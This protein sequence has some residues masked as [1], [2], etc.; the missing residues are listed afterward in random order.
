MSEEINNTESFDEA[1]NDAE[2]VIIP[3]KSSEPDTSAT[4]EQQGNQDLTAVLA[5][6]RRLQAEV[7]SLRSQKDGDDNISDA[8]ERKPA[9]YVTLAVID[10]MPIIDMKLEKELA[11][12]HKGDMY[13]KNYKAICQVFGNDDPV[14]ITYGVEG[15]PDDFLNLPRK[16]FKLTNQDPNDLSGASKVQRGVVISKDGTVPEIDRS[17]GVPVRTGKMVELVTKRDKRWYTIIV[18]EETGETCELSEDKLYR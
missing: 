10:G 6:M 7:A 8:G 18:D 15:R 3:V 17:S 2:T 5:E 16:T 1:G 13:I 9:E 14:E 4:V 12:D 11:Q